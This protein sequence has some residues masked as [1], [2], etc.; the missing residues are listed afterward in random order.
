MSSGGAPA[1]YDMNRSLLPEGG[2][3]IM[4]M[5]GGM[6]P[7]GSSG[8]PGG[9]MESGYK[10]SVLELG[11]GNIR[12]MMG[13]NGSGTAA[14]AAG[15]APGGAAA[16]ANAKAPA[17]ASASDL[18]S[19]TI[20]VLGKAFSITDPKDLNNESDLTKEHKD[21]LAQLNVSSDMVFEDKKA[22]LI[23]IYDQGCMRDSQIGLDGPCEPLRALISALSIALLG[24]VLNSGAKFDKEPDKK[25]ID[26]MVQISIKIPI[27][28]LKL[29]VAKGQGQGGEEEEET[30]A[31]PAEA[32]PVAGYQQAAS[33][34][35]ESPAEPQNPEQAEI[36]KYSK[37]PEQLNLNIAQ[38]F[39]NGNTNKEKRLKNIQ[40]GLQSTHAR[41]Y[42]SFGGTRKLRRANVAKK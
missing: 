34:E 15:G 37:N 41:G 35:M 1:G 10:E 22:I 12:G 30:I 33:M 36:N 28:V 19:K 24:K 38:A 42:R 9:Y 29:E 5:R 27:D 2:G 21:V 13:G 14:N 16:A 4:A 26:K 31:P 23:A 8:L 3:T 39:F 25:V 11:S 18:E 7:A 17:A 6:I 20:T 40:S 32:V